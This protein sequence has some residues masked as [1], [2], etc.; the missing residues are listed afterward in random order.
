MKK[1]V[2]GLVPLV[3]VER[4]SYWMMPPYF[5]A[6][7]QAGALPLMLPLTGDPDDL[8][9]LTVLCDGVLFTGGP[10]V[11]PAFYGEEKLPACGLVVPR[12]D[13][14]ELRLFRTALEAGKPVFGI[15]RGIQLINVAL[16]GSLWQDLASQKQMDAAAH[17]QKP[18]LRPALPPGIHCARQPAGRIAGKRGDGGHQPP[19]SGGQGAGPRAGSHGLLGGGPGG[20][21]A[22]AR[23]AF[24]VGGAVAPGKQLPGQRGQPQADAALDCQLQKRERNDGLTK[25]PALCWAQCGVYV[26]YRVNWM[27]Q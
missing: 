10:D 12:R 2:I 25:N 14:M 1:P 21:G 3:D 19:S 11:A 8:A 20:S 23:S 24:R 6:L 13:E 26:S 16:G 4:D 15:C 27:A 17:E 7:E 18:P 5:D 22:D 9:Q